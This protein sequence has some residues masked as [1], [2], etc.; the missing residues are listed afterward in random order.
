MTTPSSYTNATTLFERLNAPSNANALFVETASQRITYAQL[1]E[2]IR[3]AAT[4]FGQYGL[5]EGDRIVVSIADEQETILTFLSLLANGLTAILLDPDT[6]T[7]RTESI[8]Q[9]AQPKGVIADAVFF[10][11]FPGAN[12]Y[13]M[14]LSVKPEQ[15]Q[16]GQLFRKLLGK[17][18]PVTNTN[19][20]PA[21]L[22]S[23]PVGTLPTRID[24]GTVAYIL[25]TSGTTSDMKGVQITHRGLFSHLQTL[26]QV[27]GLTGES[28]L[29]NNLLLYHADGIIQGPVLAAYT[30]SVCVR[31]FGFEINRI[32]ELLDS[33]YKYRITHFIA[34][35]TMLALIQRFADGYE[36][37]FQTSD[38]Q[39]II[40]VSS[41]LEESLWRAFSERYG[42]RIVNVYGL[43]E[44]VA[45]GLF[46]GPSDDSY[47]IGTVG[48]PVDMDARIV[49]EAGQEVPDGEA[50]ELL[51]RGS[52]IMKGYL[53]N[54]AATVAV[55]QQGWLHTGDIA[56]RTTDGFY[57]ITGRL[58]NIIV[59]GGVNIH[60]EEVTEIIN[61]HPDVVESVSFG[62]ADDVFGERLISC[63]VL[64]PDSA[65]NELGLTAFCREHLEERKIPSAIFLFDDLP[66]GLSGKVQLNVMR[67]RIRQL[68]NQAASTTLDYTKLVLEAASQAFKVPVSALKPTDTSR[69]IAGWDSMAHLDFVIRLEKALGLEFDTAEI[70]V[71]NS[72]QNAESIARQKNSSR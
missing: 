23:L 43:T 42:V 57:R 40:S 70:M 29:L 50:G 59:S 15:L 44:T 55:L 12:A 18:A 35:P 16:K 65:L 64:K 38:F 56:I 58:K 51:L 48:K 24:P 39:F 26:S 13:S 69:T 49:N 45:G 62:I 2:R 17:S 8:L 20:Y 27:Y 1:S 32:G 21:L 14:A 34:V 66:K 37:S 63:V 54:E 33:I 22:Q 25:F 68:D 67:D 5:V 53:H 28:R 72:L 9:M 41:H 52:N 10:E 31:P 3:K 71:M 6:K 30:A 61:T 36:D 4:L 11:Q 60:P 46:S 47:Q 7:S 19:A